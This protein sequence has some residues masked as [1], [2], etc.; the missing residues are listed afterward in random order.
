MAQY[1]LRSFALPEALEELFTAELW[2]LGALGFEVAGGPRGQ[3]R[4][5]AYFP[6]PIPEPLISYDLT[7]WRR[8]GVTELAR[9][10]LA[11]DDWLAPYRA[12]SEPFDVGR[13]FRVDPGDPE[14][15]PERGAEGPRHLL[16]IPARA[17]FG[18]GSHPSTS[19]V[20]EWLEEL[21]LAGL[22]ILDVG[23]GSGILCFASLVLGAD[24]AVG[25]DLDAQATCLARAYATLNQVRP[26]L[27]AGSLR[28]LRPAR[29]FDL[30]LVNVLPEN[31]HG[32]LPLLGRLLAPGARLVSSANLAER[33]DELLERWRGHGFELL[34]EKQ[35]EEW[36]AW[37]LAAPAD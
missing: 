15:A 7:P 36:A 24:S 20:V 33:R 26:R 28:A 14:A 4:L 27:F 19:L 12:A 21:D 30:A 23:T 9:E 34:G 10:E 6:R 2:S 3:L 32:D 22:A 25:F 13:R 8:R 16:R 31:V 11:D 17:A 37:L 18:T 1:E 29:G 5:D 35:R